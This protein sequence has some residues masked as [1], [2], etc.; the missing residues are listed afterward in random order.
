MKDQDRHPQTFW[1]MLMLT[2]LAVMSVY[3]LF[4]SQTPEGEVAQKVGL[5]PR[6]GKTRILPERK[7]RR[8]KRVTWP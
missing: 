8:G 3:Y 2:L 1:F 7:G 4:F 6:T 5:P